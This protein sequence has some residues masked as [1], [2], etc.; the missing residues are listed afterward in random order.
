MHDG[1]ITGAYDV[2]S[3]KEP[4][5]ASYLEE[6]LLSVDRQKKLKPLYRGLRKTVPRSAFLSMPVPIPPVDDRD[7]I[8]R[9]AILE[10]AQIDEAV[11]ALLGEIALLKEYR[12]RLISDVVTGKMDVTREAAELPEIDP[13][14]LAEAF[15]GVT[16][17]SSDEV[18]DE[19]GGDDEDE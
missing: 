6:F 17:G 14:E 7:A 19:D 2:F 8:V 3:A 9:R 12:I 10:S 16:A 4:G 1:M 15:A 5:L 18:E 11:K 13:V